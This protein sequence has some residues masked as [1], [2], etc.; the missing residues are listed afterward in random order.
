MFDSR[1]ER[2]YT[3]WRNLPRKASDRDRPGPSHSVGI[4]VAAAT[5]GARH[6]RR[7]WQAGQL[8]AAAAVA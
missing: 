4:S 8:N 5:A 6:A 1:R 3:K 7:V 2:A